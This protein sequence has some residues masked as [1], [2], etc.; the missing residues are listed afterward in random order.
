MS[1]VQSRLGPSAATRGRGGQPRAPRGGG[2][3]G[4]GGG[5]SGGSYRGARAS[6]RDSSA[7]NGDAPTDGSGD[8]QSE[9]GQLRKQY[10]AQLARLMELFP[11]TA[12]NDLLFELREANG[13]LPAAA[14]KLTEGPSLP[15][16]A[17]LSL[18]LPSSL[19]LILIP[20]LSL[21]LSPSLPLSLSL[22]PSRIL[23][24]SPSLPLPLPRRTSESNSLCCFYF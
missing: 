12:V 22:S 18:P 17:P 10:S 11:H 1:E 3:G 19:A 9:V 4:G 21:P 5:G 15:P 6:A 13:D 23:S 7:T 24:H 2:G 8:E 20:S 14:D 16:L